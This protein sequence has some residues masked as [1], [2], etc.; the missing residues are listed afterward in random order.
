M[1]KGLAK[2]QTISRFAF[3]LASKVYFGPKIMDRC[4]VMGE[5]K[6][7]DLPQAE[8]VALKNTIYHDFHS[9]GTVQPNSSLCGTAVLKRSMASIIGRGQAEAQYT[10]GLVPLPT[11]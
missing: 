3:K 4:T 7:P 9:L 10:H 11:S 8:L 2:E 5:Q 1:N 6:L